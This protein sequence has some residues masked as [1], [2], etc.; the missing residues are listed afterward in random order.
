[1]TKKNLAFIAITCL[2]IL[3]FSIG[4]SLGTKASAN[5]KIDEEKTAHELLQEK[6]NN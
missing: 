5:E 2:L 1:M 4:Y 3:G 6:T